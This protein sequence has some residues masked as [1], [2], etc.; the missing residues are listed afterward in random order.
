MAAAAFFAVQ[1]PAYRS[2][3]FYLFFLLFMSNSIAIALV[4]IGILVFLSHLFASLFSKKMVPD[5]L[6]L[7]VI[8]VI[9]GPVLGLVLPQ[10]FGKV[11][12]VFTT[13][14]L[15]V[16]L[17][18]GGISLSLDT[19]KR[20]WKSTMT[21]T[22]SCFVVLVVAVTLIAYVAFGFPFLSA[23]VLGA[24]LA[25]TSSAVVIPLVSKLPLG[26]ETKTALILESALTDVFCIVLALACIQT[27]VSGEINIGTTIGGVVSSFVLATLVGVFAA[28]VWARVLTKIRHIQNSIF[29]TPAFVFL[30]Y[31]ISELLGFNGAISALAF[32]VAMANLEVFKGFIVRKIMG[33][34][35]HKLND[36]E[37]IFLREITFLL[38]TFFFVYIGLSIIF[39]D[40]RSLIYGG[41]LTVV[42]Y[43]IRL[44]VAKYSSPKSA[45][46][47]DKSV[48]SMMSP[49]GLAA[50]VLASIPEM[51]GM[52]EGTTIKNTV[53]AIVFFSIVLT[54]VL[55]LIN[56]KSVSLQNFYAAFF[57]K[58]N[59]L[60]Q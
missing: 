17:F 42:M 45:S 8:G 7:I 46:V 33:G 31:G 60:E 11:G 58:Q 43:V 13:V 23:L 1:N 6:L 52:P 25:G 57:G 55:I 41:I 2:A 48:V 27:Y 10:Y 29:T 44:F 24:I 37:V 54:S 49:K 38:K 9:I 5:V 40:A 22:M 21:L 28:L 18:E 47:F 39:N 26:D 4:A 50:A 59:H 15:V 30:I 12:A 32:G 51:V 56:N 53:Y 3:F 35:P 19:L 20:S 16:I 34:Q 14:T 36:T